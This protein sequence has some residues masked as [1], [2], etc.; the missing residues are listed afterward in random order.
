L[1]QQIYYKSRDIQK[2]KVEYETLK[3]ENKKINA[4][5]EEIKFKNQVLDTIF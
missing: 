1:T 3:A 4:S 2:F 5:V